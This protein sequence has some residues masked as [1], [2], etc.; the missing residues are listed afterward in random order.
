MIIGTAGHI[1]HGKT[2]LV[3]RMTGVDTDRLPEE[4][5]RGMT[6]EL[7]FAHMD[8]PGGGQVGLVDVPGHERFVRTM[9]AGATGI[10]M[11]L[12]V[13]AADDGV[14]P[15]TRE[16]L[17]IIDLLGIATGVV[18]VSKADLVSTERVEGVRS[19]IRDLVAGTVLADAPI[20]PV[21]AITGEGV[22]ALRAALVETL[23]ALRAR[24]DDGP[25]WMAV[26]RVFTVQGFGLVCTGTVRSGAV[27]ND[28]QVRLLPGG[29]T[30]RVRRVQTHGRTVDGVG[31]GSRC[32]LNLAGVDKRDVRRGMVVCDAGLGHVASTVDAR[33][34]QVRGLAKPIRSHSRVRFHSGTVETIAR[35]QWL[36]DAPPTPGA[37]GLAQLRL[38][39]P[40]PLLYGHRFVLR[41]EPGQHTL[42]GGVVL[43]PMALR[44]GARRPDRL[45]ALR[46]L[47]KLDTTEAIDTLLERRGADG[48]TLPDLAERLADV[49]AR[50]DA[51]MG[52][53]DDV[54]REEL[55][56]TLW[57]ASRRAVEE[58]MPRMV[59]AVAEFL[60]VNP[61]ATAMPS[62]TLRSAVC[63]RLDRRV[64]RTL[65]D[66]MI[67]A[68]DLEVVAD[69]VRP[70]GH[71]QHFSAEAEA[72][73]RMVTDHLA[74]EDQP[75]PKVETLAHRIG[76]SLPRLRQ[77]LGELERAGRVVRI[78][79]DFY[80]NKPEL[81]AWRDL[82]RA[83]LAENGEMSAAQFRD[84]AGIGRNFSIVLLEHLDREG[85]TRRVGNVRVAAE[86]GAGVER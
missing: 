60:A 54:W 36:E 23:A 75:P 32:A 25:F 48:W 51:L 13:V 38:D 41:D 24:S 70:V 46:R 77:F 10:D 69:G 64:F 19:D 82:V 66:R 4:K 5:K 85:V 42:G 26:D 86:R 65:L 11:V 45:A 61:R 73:A 83:Y 21:S 43:D 76:Q 3:R 15:Q 74:Y 52:G 81:D 17:E 2:A 39:D 14:M 80:V 57:L 62:A 33:V 12:L 35:I 68:G 58:L 6:I 72:L 49:P 18:A 56:G 7:G 40:V 16:H 27:A 28:N 67:A 53:R 55:E 34:T 37:G 20:I 59:A 30:V 9:V 71:R 22:E 47:A 31:T 84:A 44:R 1:D 50:I 8:L 79:R 29:R 78:D 63:P